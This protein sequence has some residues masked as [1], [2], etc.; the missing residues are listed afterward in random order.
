[1]HLPPESRFRMPRIG[2]EVLAVCGKAETRKR[3]M[4]VAECVRRVLIGDFFIFFLPPAVYSS[5]S[6]GSP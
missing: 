5:V 4:R 3:W 6:T 1:M 2:I